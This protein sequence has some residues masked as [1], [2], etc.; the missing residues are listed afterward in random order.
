MICA[1]EHE[2]EYPNTVPSY[3]PSPMGLSILYS[4]I[5]KKYALRK[6]KKK[7]SHQNDTATADCGC[8]HK[9]NWVFWKLGR[10]SSSLRKR[11]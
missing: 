7:E 10:F 3:I 6:S 2:D 8:F 4:K 9:K 11:N 5:R 1:K